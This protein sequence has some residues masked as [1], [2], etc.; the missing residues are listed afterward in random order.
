MRPMSHKPTIVTIFGGTGFIGSQIVRAAAQRGW[1]VKIAT[2]IPE[3]AYF[4]RPCG[5]VGQI[6][7]YHCDYSD[8]QAIADAVKGS[9]YVVNCIGILYERRKGDFTKAHTAIPEMIATACRT[10][11]VK[12][13]VHISSLGVTGDSRYGQSKK[14]GDEAVSRAFPDATILRPGVVFGAGDSFFNLFAGLA[15]LLPALP[16]IGGGHT[17]FQPVFV[18]DVTEASLAALTLPPLGD[19]DPRG[20]IYELGG[21]EIVDF[22]EIYARLF[23]HTGRQ[24]ALIPL[25]WGV[26]RIQA[27]LLSLLPQ[28]LLTP[29]QVQSL[30]HDTIIAKNALTLADL[31]VTATGMDLILPQYLVQYRPGGR[32]SHS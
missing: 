1:V 30:K 19:Q 3:R 11:D 2:R 5:A 4:L 25:P 31:G 12:R 8:P 24:R 23:R 29:D 10:H 6:V 9:D 20:K 7:P 15:C 27:F 21:P 13:F 28:P 14:A 16:L 32:F 26:A 17:K 22:R 18:G